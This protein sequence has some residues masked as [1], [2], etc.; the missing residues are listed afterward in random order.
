MP[1]RNFAYGLGRNVQHD[2]RSWNFPVRQATKP[3]TVLW[4]HKAPV[5]DQGQ[6]GSCTGNALTQ[7][8]NTEF[9]TA[10]RPGGGYLDELDAI[11]LYSKATELDDIDGTY[12]PDDTGSS[13]I[14]VCKA[15]VSLKYLT[16]YTHPM[17]LDD[18]CG[19]LTLS[20]LIV[21]VDWYYA[22]EETDA[23]GFV[24]PKG[25]IAGGHEICLLGQDLERGFFTFL[26]SWGPEWGKSGRFYMTTA[27]FAKLLKSDGDATVPVGLNIAPAPTPVPTPAPAADNGATA[28]VK[29]I[30]SLVKD[31][32]G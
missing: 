29:Q 15:G 22:M 11:D 21:G 30:Q 7:C 4:D 19:A 8:L 25:Q 2:P 3:K 24:W 32:K 27:A 12:P 31:F 6:L 18:V 10:S 5:L 1:I 9:F 16:G 20:P 13:G 14:G 17:G 26:N 23:R 28:I